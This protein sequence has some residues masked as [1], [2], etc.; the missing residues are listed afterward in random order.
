MCE[1]ICWPEMPK[2][3]NE[4]EYPGQWIYSKSR[5]TQY[6]FTQ[7]QQLRTLLAK[8]LSLKN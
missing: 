2:L 5:L 3:V 6:C 4:L 8:I 7:I 1:F